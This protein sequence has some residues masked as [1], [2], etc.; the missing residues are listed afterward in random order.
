MKRAICTMNCLLTDAI[1][2]VPAIWT[3]DSGFGTMQAGMEFHNRVYAGYKKLA[4]ENPSRFVCVDG[5]QTPEEIFNQI[6][7][8]LK[9]RNCL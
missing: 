8:V 2:T 9:E 5:N 7:A 6:V 4:E 1:Y 3:G